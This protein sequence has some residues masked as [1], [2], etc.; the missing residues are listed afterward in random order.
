MTIKFYDKVADLVA[1]DNIQAVGSRC[2]ALMGSKRHL[3]LFDKRL[4]NAQLHGLTRCEVSLHYRQQGGL[5]FT[6]HLCD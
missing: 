1:R 4:R 2:N 3:D 5:I 6:D